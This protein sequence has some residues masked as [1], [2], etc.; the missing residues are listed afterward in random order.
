MTDPGRIFE[1]ARKSSVFTVTEDHLK[2]LRQAHVVWE[3]T[4]FGA[5]AIDGKR[6]YGNSDVLDDI[7]GILEIDGDIYDGDPEDREVKPHV[8]ERL[9]QLHA[10]TGVVLQI[11][12]ATGRFEAG[13]YR[14]TCPYSD[15]WV[16][17]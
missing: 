14:K 8:K 13:T 9:N 12:L 16:R 10:E 1:I 7:I 3:Y 5:P 11:A 4:E 15:N 6:P 2:L 17:I